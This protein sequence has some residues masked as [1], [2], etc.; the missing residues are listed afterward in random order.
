MRVFSDWC[1][2]ERG[3]AI[4]TSFSEEGSRMPDHELTITSE[5]QRAS[6]TAWVAD[7]A[8]GSRNTHSETTRAVSCRLR[9]APS[10]SVLLCRACVVALHIDQPA[11]IRG[12]TKM[13]HTAVLKG[14]NARSATTTES[15]SNI[16][17]TNPKRRPPPSI[18]P[19][20]CLSSDH[21]LLR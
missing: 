8:G 6:Q 4:E 20:L 13:A 16:I 18:P 21:G 19:T 2:R 3:F 5:R 10:S 15:S 12:H 9:I 14:P 1:E 7:A 17:P 11:M